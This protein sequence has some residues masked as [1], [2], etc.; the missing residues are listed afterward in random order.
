MSS[1]IGASSVHKRLSFGAAV[2]NTLD[3]VSSGV[4]VRVSLIMAVS[5]AWICDGSCLARLYA[6]PLC[7]SP[8][9]VLLRGVLTHRD[10]LWFNGNHITCFPAARRKY[11]LK[12]PSQSEH[13]AFEGLSFA[14]AAVFYAKVRTESARVSGDNL[15]DSGS[16]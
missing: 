2:G 14:S 8:R 16:N 9:L 11:R 12:G 3:E 5:H 13:E 6:W 7:Q 10:V 1:G 15:E 4:K